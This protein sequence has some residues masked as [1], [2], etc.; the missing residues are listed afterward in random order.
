MCSSR[1]AWLFDSLLYEWCAREEVWPRKAVRRL[2]FDI[3][4]DLAL[5]TAAWCAAGMV[6]ARR[7]L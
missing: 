3:G 7:D 6:A 2:T 4:L 5:P 1:A